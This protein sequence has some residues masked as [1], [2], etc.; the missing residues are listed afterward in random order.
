M[1]KVTSQAMDIGGQITPLGSPINSYVEISTD[2]PSGMT[3]K[4][5]H[6]TESSAPPI[7]ALPPINWLPGEVVADT[8][9][10]VGCH[11]VQTN[12]RLCI[13]S[14][15]DQSVAVIPLMNIE[16]LDLRDL[17]NVSISCKD[18]RVYRITAPSYELAMTWHRKLLKCSNRS[19]TEDAF[20]WTFAE[21]CTKDNCD[22]LAD[23]N[24]IDSDLCQA[25]WKRLDYDPDHF[26]ISDINKNFDFVETY[27]SRLVLL[28]NI[29][30]EEIREAADFRFLK[31]FPVV[32]W[33]SKETKAILLRSSQPRAGILSWRNNK[34]EKYLKLISEYMAAYHKENAPRTI[35]MDARSYAAAFAN[36]AKG[37]GYE[38]TDYYPG[39][40]TLFLG[41]PNIHHVRYAFIQLRNLYSTPGGNDPNTYFQNLQTTSWLQY[42]RQLLLAGCQCADVLQNG[43]SVLVHCSDGWDRTSQIVSLAKLMVDDYYKTI[44]GFC[45]LITR[46][47]IEF[48]HKFSDRNGVSGNDA[49]ERS[50]IFLQWIDAVWQLFSANETSF[51]F[52][53]NFLLKL[54]QH[55]Y[56]GLFGNFLFNSSRDSNNM[57]KNSISIWRFLCL[58]NESVVNHLYKPGAPL[59][60]DFSIDRIKVWKTCYCNADFLN[61][62]E[63]TAIASPV[64]QDFISS[65]PKDNISIQKSKSSE[66][67]N[68]IEQSSMGGFHTESNIMNGIGE[69]ALDTSVISESTVPVRQGSRHRSQKEKDPNKVKELIDSDGLVRFFDKIQIRVLE[70]DKEHKAEISK[71]QVEADLLKQK[72]EDV[73][74]SSIPECANRQR[75]ASE[76][77]HDNKRNSCGRVYSTSEESEQALSHAYSDIS[78]IESSEALPPLTTGYSMESDRCEICKKSFSKF[79]ISDARRHHCRNCWKTVC[80]T[81]SPNL[82]HVVNNG[83]GVKERVCNICYINM[84]VA[85]PEG[86][87][88]LADDVSTC[89]DSTTT[90]MKTSTC[91][92]GNGSS[93][94]NTSSGS[95]SSSSSSN[96]NR[97][98]SDTFV[99]GFRNGGLA[100]TP[101]VKG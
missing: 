37:G 3:G 56:S 75:Y 34:D 40:E 41:L 14:K 67:L 100:T 42:T 5:E 72:L 77:I 99:N 94:A 80:E 13:F 10:F 31:R 79:S 21:F 51:E 19:K 64:R 39:T 32:V 44:K 71:A 35:I 18:G 60:L 57:K 86:I 33:K 8:A 30:D 76:G 47:W 87:D 58:Q 29:K 91:S 98:R 55:S 46:E 82:F 38:I 63:N 54:A 23:E 15:A 50:P 20:A 90:N 53:E 7:E 28:K 2:Q 73:Q 25:E 65:S 22:W 4:V 78:I 93:T 12:F 61:L 96:E 48:G 69:H 74:N 9:A 83:H 101:A 89:S 68:S 6:G 24:G 26:T 81:C 1:A 52:N 84:E 49:N 92:V 70:K 16:C 97:H 95:S 27:P 85:I 11:L 59:E 66:S 17:I 43:N 45:E 36:R 62:S 88:S